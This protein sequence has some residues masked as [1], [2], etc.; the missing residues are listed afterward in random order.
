MKRT[1]VLIASYN[2]A[3]FLPAALDSAFSQTVPQEEYEVLVVDDASTDSTEQAVAPYRDR[4]NFRYL[5]NVRNLGL[6]GACNKGLEAARGD[7]LVRLDA[8]DLFDPDLL[9]ELRGPLD[10]EE[11]DLVSCDRREKE[12]ATGAVREVRIEPFNLFKLIA[13]GT[14]MRR[15]LL[16]KIGGWRDLF[17]EEY[18]L[19][20]RYLS[21]CGRPPLH[22]PKV[23]LTYQL[24]AGS[25]SSDPAR[26]EAGW[27]ELA[28]LWPS[29]V[30][31][32][33]REMA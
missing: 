15:E 5:K 14:M 24:R 22:I 11:A 17:F 1:T 4:P 25:M 18:D 16:E 32:S 2:N 12:L 28:A 7:Y 20:L 10:R 21:R 26:V 6:A 29:E 31:K 9:W 27:Q 30:L 3:G 8:D 23:L 19:Y 13:I 33:A